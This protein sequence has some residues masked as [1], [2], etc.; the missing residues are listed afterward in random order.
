MSMVEMQAALARLYVDGPFLD[1]FCADPGTVLRDYD[2]TPREAGALAALDREAVRKFAGSLRS[3]TWGRFRVPYVLLRALSPA[4]TFRYFKRFYELRT[5]RPNEPFYAL[6]LELGEFFERSFSGNP[7]LPPYASELARYERLFF[8]ARFRPRAGGETPGSARS[9]AGTLTRDSRPA[10]RP[11]ITRAR[12]DYD[13]RA[14]DRALSEGTVP[15]GVEKKECQVVFQSFEQLGRARKFRVSPATAELLTL[16]DG[17]RDL[18]AIAA[19]LGG[20]VEAVVEAAT[21]L[22][23]HGVVT[24]GGVS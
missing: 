24:A 10:A 17:T 13:M 1:R 7:E 11:G 19:L 14:L 12:F 3:K 15:E 9:V 21:S 2:L 4:I 20:G 8:I 16:C 6:T 22:F 23:R 18:A 5:V